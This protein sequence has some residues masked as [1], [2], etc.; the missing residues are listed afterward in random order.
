MG[1]F[2]RN[3]G[4]FGILLGSMSISLYRNNFLSLRWGDD[5]HDSMFE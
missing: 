3:D 2:V 5:L 1:G 4:S